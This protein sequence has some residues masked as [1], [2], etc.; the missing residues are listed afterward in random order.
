MSKGDTQR[1][2]DLKKFETNYERIFRSQHHLASKTTMPLKRT[3]LGVGGK[4]EPLL[5]LDT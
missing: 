5:N 3:E 1:P 4:N 2:V